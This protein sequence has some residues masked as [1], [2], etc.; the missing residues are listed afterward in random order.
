[1]TTWK[2]YKLGE[3]ADVVMGQSP[4]GETCNTIMIGYPLLNGPTEFGTHHPI[5]THVYD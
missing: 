5:P 3:I 1:M 4:K 2:E